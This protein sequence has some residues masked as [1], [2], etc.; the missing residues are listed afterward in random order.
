MSR[1][2]EADIAAS[3]AARCEGLG[4]ALFE[5]LSVAGGRPFADLF[6]ILK[7]QLDTR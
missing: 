4:G 1:K 7:L 6:F 3:P 5:I 2:Q